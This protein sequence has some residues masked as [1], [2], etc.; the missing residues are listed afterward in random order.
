LFRTTINYYL[1]NLSVA[2]LLISAWCPWTS[3]T[4]QVLAPTSH[5]ILPPIF[6]KLD[7]FYRVLCIVASVLTLSAIS[8]DRSVSISVARWPFPLALSSTVVFF[9]DE[10]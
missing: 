2:D 5:Y 8:F 4:H 10:R 3:L 1:V 7:V 9:N 6:C